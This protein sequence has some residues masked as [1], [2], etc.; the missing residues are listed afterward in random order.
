MKLPTTP[1]GSRL[2]ERRVALT[3]TQ[4]EVAERVGAFPAQISYFEIGE[5]RPRPEM[6]IALA[7]ALS[8]TVDWLLSRSGAP[9]LSATD[10]IEPINETLKDMLDDVV[11][12]FSSADKHALLRYYQFLKSQPLM[13]SP[14]GQD[15]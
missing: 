6:L 2:R 3:L 15:T 1:L 13:F 11:E 8:C 9:E 4:S 12:T 14:E 10:T 7:D 5:R